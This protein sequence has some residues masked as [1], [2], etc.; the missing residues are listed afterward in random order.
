MG[1]FLQFLTEFLPTTGK[2]Q[3]TIVSYSFIS[4]SELEEGCG[5]DHQLNHEWLPGISRSCS[6]SPRRSG[7]DHLSVQARN[8][9]FGAQG[10]LPSKTLG[11]IGKIWGQYSFWFLK[12]TICLS[13]FFFTCFWFVTIAFCRSSWGLKVRLIACRL[14]RAFFT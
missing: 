9:S 5:A 10:P 8:F 6:R 4:F 14:G 13:T 11:T 2:W 7:N 12:A 1:R 3:D